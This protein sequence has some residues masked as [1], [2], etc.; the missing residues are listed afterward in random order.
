M[1][2]KNEGTILIVDDDPYIL[3]STSLLLNQYGYITI[4]CDN[5][6]DA[7][8]QLHSNKIDIVLSDIKMP[9]VSGIEL[10]DQIH[11]FNS[12]MPVILMTA[13]AE[14]DSAIDAII[15]GVFDFIT[16]PYRPEYLAKRIERALEYNNLLQLKK[17]YTSTLKKTIRKK[18]KELEEALF[19]VES[20][21]REIIQ[22]LA[23]VAEFR[24]KDT[25][26][27]THRI[28]LYT[29]K[30]AESMSIPSNFVD[31][32]TYASTLHDIG[33]VGI[34][35]KILQKAGP[36]TFEE[37]K[38]MKSH[39]T[40]GYEI[41][42]QSS[43]PVIQMAASIALSHH[44]KWDGKGYPYGLKGEEIPIE[45]RI[46]IICDH[47]DALMSKRPYKSALTHQKV[48]EIITEGSEKTNPEQFD[49]YVLKKFIEIAPIFF[50][51]IYNSHK[52]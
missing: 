22:H 18:T 17:N 3:E 28:S 27:H 24:D 52:C 47:Y 16:K 31:I 19:Q 32:L 33:K 25:G 41:L 2:L 36:L 14:I 43:H 49:P 12:E 40:I 51:E 7:M 37:F 44:E 46:L 42:H 50:E 34:P 15:Y 11:K 30:I 38:I 6:H 9:G 1:E 29:K 8:Q 48:F 39:T 20:L 26:L 23:S 4:T 21:S 5:A 10:L 45:G 35:D 13:Y